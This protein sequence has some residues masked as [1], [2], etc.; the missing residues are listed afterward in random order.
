MAAHLLRL[1]ADSRRCRFGRSVS[2]AFLSSY[3]LGPREVGAHMEGVFVDGTLRAVAE[4]RPIGRPLA[5]H[6]EAALTVERPFRE[7]GLGSLLLRQLVIHAQNQ[8]ILDVAMFC[9]PENTPMRRLAASQG[10]TQV[11]LSSDVEAIIHEPPPSPFSVLREAVH[12]A[13]P[14]VQRALEAFEPFQRAAPRRN[15][16]D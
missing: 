8:G 14:Y 6:A 2:D 15:A 11:R 5:L 4:L 13:Q 7:M 1:D 16:A 10:A 12:R 3:A 9:L